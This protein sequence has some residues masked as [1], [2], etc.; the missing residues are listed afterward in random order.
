MSA[1]DCDDSHCGSVLANWRMRRE[2]PKNKC[3][4]AKALGVVAAPVRV[5]ARPVPEDASVPREAPT[6][7]QIRATRLL[8]AVASAVADVAATAAKVPPRPRPTAKPTTKAARDLARERD[9]ADRLAEAIADRREGSIRNNPELFAI[10][11]ELVAARETR[12]AHVT[13]KREA[14]RHPFDRMEVEY[15][16]KVVLDGNYNEDARNCDRI[17]SM[18]ALATRE[19]GFELDINS[20]DG[21]NVFGAA[22]LGAR[23][24]KYRPP[25]YFGGGSVKSSRKTVEFYASFRERSQ[26]G[27]RLYAKL[28]V[29]ACEKAGYSPVIYTEAGFNEGMPEGDRSVGQARA[30]DRGEVERKLRALIPRAVAAWA[31]GLTANDVAVIENRRKADSSGLSGALSQEFR[32][33]SANLLALAH[34]QGIAHDEIEEMAQKIRF[35][36]QLEKAYLAALPRF[37]LE[38]DRKTDRTR[39]FVEERKIVMDTKLTEE[40]R[41]RTA[42][43]I[44]TE[45]KTQARITID[46]EAPGT[47]SRRIRDAWFVGI[48]IIVGNNGPE[49]LFAMQQAQR[50]LGRLTTN[51]PFVRRFNRNSYYESR[52]DGTGVNQYGEP[53]PGFAS[54]RKQ[55]EWDRKL[56][57]RQKRQTALY[58]SVSSGEGSLPELLAAAAAIESTASTVLSFLGYK[59]VT[60]WPA[61]AANMREALAH[62]ARKYAKEN[63]PVQQPVADAAAVHDAELVKA[64]RD[65]LRESALMYAGGWGRRRLDDEEY[66]A[67]FVREGKLPSSLAEEIEREILSDVR[68]SKGR[69][70]LAALHETVGDDGMTLSERLA[71]RAALAH[72]EEAARKLYQP[73]SPAAPA[74]PE[75]VEDAR[76]EGLPYEQRELAEQVREELRK[77]AMGLGRDFINDLEREGRPALDASILRGEPLAPVLVEELTKELVDLMRDLSEKTATL[78]ESPDAEGL[79]LSMRLA[80]EGGLRTAERT[81]QAIYAHKAKK[82]EERLTATK[83]AA[84]ERTLPRTATQVYAGIAYAM[85][86]REVYYQRRRMALVRLPDTSPDSWF[87]WTLG[88][89]D[90][91]QRPYVVESLAK[92]QSESLEIIVPNGQRRED[93]RVIDRPQVGARV[94]GMLSPPGGDDTVSVSEYAWA[95]G[96]APA[97]LVGECQVIAVKESESD[98]SRVLTL[99]SS[100]GIA[101]YDVRQSGRRSELE[102]LVLAS[103]RLIEASSMREEPTAIEAELRGLSTPSVATAPP[104]PEKTTEGPPAELR[105]LGFKLPVERAGVKPSKAAELSLEAYSMSGSVAIVAQGR[106]T[107]AAKELLK[108]LGF[109]FSRGR[110]GIDAGWWVD[111]RNVSELVMPW[112]YTRIS[113]AIAR[114]Y[115]IDWP[116]AGLL[117]DAAGL[118]WETAAQ[119]SAREKGIVEEA[120]AFKFTVDYRDIRGGSGVWYTIDAPREAWAMVKPLGWDYQAPLA[121]CRRSECRACAARLGQCYFAT[122]P[123]VAKT[124][125]NMMTP[126]A[127]AAIDKLEQEI[128]ASKAT[129]GTIDCPL[130]PGVKLYGYQNAGVSYALSR[131]RVLIA[132]EMGLGK[133][134]QSIVTCAC[135]PE[136]KRVL[137]IVPA[138]LRRNWTRE[139]GVFS[140]RKGI[141]A[142]LKDSVSMRKGETKEEAQDRLLRTNVATITA[143]TPD[144]TWVVVGYEEAMT[145]AGKALDAGS[146]DAVILDEAQAIKNVDAQRTIRA[147]ELWERSRKRRIML[148]GTPIENNLAELY[149]LCSL[150]DPVTY[151]PGG[152]FPKN[153]KYREKDRKELE[154]S[155]RKS[156]MVR[157]LKSEVLTDLPEKRWSLVELDGPE[158]DDAR[159]EWSD[160]KQATGYGNRPS[161][162]AESPRMKQKAELES[163]LDIA[164][165]MKDRAKVRAL[166]AQL[167]ELSPGGVDF[168]DMSRVRALTGRAKVSLALEHINSK[169]ASTPAEER[170]LVVW[171]HH[172]EVAEALAEGIRKAGYSAEVANGRRDSE[173]RARIVADFQSGKLNVAV[174]TIG[175]MGT[176][177][178]MT[179]A[180]EAFFVEFPWTPAKLVQAEDR[181][182]RIGQKR[183]VMITYLFADDTLDVRMLAILQDKEV[184][185]ESTLDNDTEAH[186]VPDRSADILANINQKGA[187]LGRASDEEIAAVTRDWTQ[188][189]KRAGRA[190]VRR[191]EAIYEYSL[192]EKA[193]LQ[194]AMESLRGQCDRAMTQDGCGFAGPDVSIGWQM[195]DI[196][197]VQWTDELATLGHKL[198][199]KYRNQL[200]GE[201][202]ERKPRPLSKEARID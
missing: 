183:G 164:R 184:L 76:A 114:D 135:D 96:T 52:P 167:Q 31:K 133:T 14:V 181:I 141:V 36:A 77:E 180:N 80:I 28:L 160:F 4:D 108:K 153:L 98:A 169:L 149:N 94:L 62:F 117:V 152:S 60:E 75:L 101:R 13:L 95:I 56:L 134:P 179:R 202:L 12:S 44:V 110:Q 107:F 5:I 112:D 69:E 24:Y 58:A 99:R 11:R 147:R 191:S 195:A 26:A 174:C 144:M 8:D 35:D 199:I 125:R 131:S 19:A 150:C 64:W 176:G 66:R 70:T 194:S 65:E 32:I 122:D 59:T 6:A 158:L 22:P 3:G 57:L 120:A 27:I 16:V 201:L 198:S 48:A 157:R 91:E 40:Q 51:D 47:G 105:A 161:E 81:A 83:K 188:Q 104:V 126:A 89:V 42:E 146:F 23:K 67:A 173:T 145:S 34:E 143:E 182:H 200:G 118:R 100:S 38:S 142:R 79:T 25:P 139:I 175:A 178:T 68:Y 136:V 2:P 102:G 45:L 20:G 49:D 93:F 123:S 37:D 61:G 130:P 119:A 121:D 168:A 148:T 54:K 113:A 129:D 132:D 72:V 127:V 1:V 172:D 115:K 140:A 137:V 192:E 111:V 86:V 78:R 124:L 39:A 18:A 185:S 159:R 171:A 97:E 138:S 156:F 193:I 50:A 53:P 55:T 196:P 186:E 166:T 162:D 85:G 84:D 109:R 71:I 177:H 187:A 170:S 17:A 41:E 88:L 116:V 30:Q 163:Q 189:V 29:A 87:G 33:V 9:R 197:A 82:E 92:M 7:G 154:I 10:D 103:M 21:C 165:A 128:A 190:A 73:E 106:G 15:D 63:R 151:P 43:R 155:M 90:P 74:V 46:V